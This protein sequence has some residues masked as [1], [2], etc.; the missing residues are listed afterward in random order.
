MSP[1]HSVSLRLRLFSLRLF[2]YHEHNLSVYCS[3][4]DSFPDSLYCSLSLSFYL[5]REHLQSGSAVVC[6][7][8]YLVICVV[9]YLVICI[10]PYLVICIVRHLFEVLSQALLRAG[11][12]PGF[13]ELMRANEL[14]A[15]DGALN[16][17]A[18]VLEQAQGVPPYC[19]SHSLHCV[20]HRA[21]SDPPHCRSHRFASHP[22]R[23]R[24]LTAS[25]RYLTYRDASAL[26]RCLSHHTA[27]HLLHCLLPT[28]LPLTP[29]CN[30]PVP[31]AVIL[32]VHRAW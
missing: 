14:E 22:P 10:V 4:A 9:P 21:A 15:A 12:L 27:S 30:R 2:L 28:M 25:L 29:H 26:L 18:L 24:S 11:V 17:V 16:F 20:S 6:L 32:N 8:P 31:T 19:L 1:S 13:L 5:K 23:C 3:H 7:V